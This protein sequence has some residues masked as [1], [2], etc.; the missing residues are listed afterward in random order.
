MTARH[1][2]SFADL[3]R[4]RIFDELAAS[5]DGRWVA[6]TMSRPYPGETPP[7]GSRITILDLQRNTRRVLALGGDARGM[8]WSPLGS[9]LAFIAPSKNKAT[10]WLYSPTDP[11]GKARPLQAT[12]RLDRDVRAMAWSPSGTHISYLARDLPTPSADS[13]TAP[14][15]IVIFRDEPGVVTGSTSGYRPDSAGMHLAIA[16]I[17]GGSSRIVARNLVTLQGL[18][19]TIHWSRSGQ[20]L[21]GGGP[22]GKASPQVLSERRLY[23]VEASSGTARQ[24]APDYPGRFRATLSPSGHLSAYL[25]YEHLPERPRIPGMFSLRLAGLRRSDS[26]IRPS[27]ESEMDGF[28]SSLPP[29][30]SNDR[31]LVVGRYVD[32]TARLY[33]VDLPSRRWRQLTPDTLSAS[34]YAT[35]SGGKVL[36]VVLENVNQQQELYLVEPRTGALTQLTHEGGNDPAL[37]LGQVDQVE[38]LSADRRFTVHGFLVKPPDYDPRR[39]HPLIVMIHGGPGAPYSNSYTEV[40]FGLGTPPPQLIAA[41][42]YLVLLPNP[43]G[44]QSYGL[45]YR[46]AIHGDLALGPYAD[47]SGG[48]AALI[49]RGLVDSTAVGIYGSSYGAYLGAYA[50]TQTHRFAAAVIDDGPV[51]LA[52]LYGQSY[53]INSP[54]L[55]HYLDGSP[56]T[57]AERYRSQSPIS[58]ADRVRTPVLMRYGGRSA[59]GDNIRPSYMLAQGLEFYAALRDHDVPVEFIIHPDQPHSVEDWGLFQDWTH[60]ILS[61]FG[62]WLVQEGS[63]LTGEHSVVP[64]PEA[65]P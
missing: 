41:P 14:L 49:H 2:P 53:A 42:G 47:V 33:A 12:D 44:D 37:R 46:D 27:A 4:I 40:N 36:L 18:P 22:L 35:A 26:V 10:I 58:H 20:M 54:L 23:L 11:S 61:W 56:W 25:E 38:W 5:P 7:V 15:R 43:R 31:T 62:R 9:T 19:P 24:I 28:I 45:S 50:I 32:A 64:L 65:R 17:D 30:W 8:A 34:V 59:T 39:R 55:R 6:Y 51:N 21:I 60:R 48:V 52:S 57:Q 3:P 1:V 16:S 63:S 13:A 29:L